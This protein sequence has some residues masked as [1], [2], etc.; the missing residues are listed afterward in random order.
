MLL[1]QC[2]STLKLSPLDRLPL[3]CHCQPPNPPL[4]KSALLLMVMMLHHT[5][6]GNWQKHMFALMMLVFTNSSITG[7][8]N[9]N[10][11]YHPSAAG[12]FVFKETKMIAFRYV[13]QITHVLSMLNHQVEDACLCRALYH[14]YPQA[15]KLNTPYLQA[16][17]SSHALHI[18]DKCTCT[19]E[20]NKCWW[21]Y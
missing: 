19:P 8:P 1:E 13:S 20:F 6:Y 17:S 14:C 10:L 16:T 3:S 11:T 2:F 7:K 12:R 5:G 4:E 21:S 9:I 18:G 15:A